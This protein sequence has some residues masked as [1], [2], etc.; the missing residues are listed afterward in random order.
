MLVALRKKFGHN[1]CSEEEFR[2]EVLEVCKY[3]GINDFLEQCSQA[4]AR[5]VVLTRYAAKKL[6]DQEEFCYFM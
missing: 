3:T 4:M 1:N 6:T 5:Q 2:R